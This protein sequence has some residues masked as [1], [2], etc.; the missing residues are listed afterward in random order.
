MFHTF[1]FQPIF[2]VLAIIYG[3]LPGHNFG[4]AIILFTI[5]VRILMWP[6]VKKQLHH[7][8]A[9]KALQP[10]LKRIKKEAAGDKQKESAMVMALYKEREVNPFSSIGVLILQ[11]PILIALYQGI[12]K[13]VANQNAL[14]EQSY[15]FVRNLPG[16]Q[17][18]ADGGKLDNTLLGVVDLGRAAHSQQ[19]WYLGALMIAVGSAAAQ[20]FQSKQLMPTDKNARSL[21]KIL[22]QASSGE[23]ADQSE[24]NAAVSRTTLYLLPG[25][26]MVFAVGLPA[27]LP[28]YWLA[29]SIVAYIQQ[30][31]V[32][33]DDE[34]ELEALADAPL[35]A[36]NGSGAGK[37]KRT[38]LDPDAERKFVPNL[39]A[40]SGKAAVS[41]KTGS[42]TT[43]GSYK[44]KT[45]QDFK[46]RLAQK[47]AENTQNKAAKTS[48]TTTSVVIRGPG[49][50]HKEE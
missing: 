36:A 17:Q 25:M 6:L 37:K 4:L 3:L 14:L 28:L 50:K 32:L 46:S 13:I 10:E 39:A 21:R 44:A 29:G 33:K 34:V 7:A 31:R 49:Q 12:Q 26:L 45:K 9:M 20:Y 22:K 40:S 23:Q 24:V 19:G 38:A 41:S 30:A 18:L 15:G 43:K 16:L 35:S 47:L 42:A 27:A 48:K 2:N 5:V 11:L 1:V 8:K